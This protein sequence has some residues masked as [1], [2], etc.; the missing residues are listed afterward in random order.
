[1]SRF[2]VTIPRNPTGS[3]LHTVLY[4]YMTLYKYGIWIGHDVCIILIIA[5]LVVNG[6]V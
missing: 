1:M 3:I 2:A 5:R 6:T 4:T